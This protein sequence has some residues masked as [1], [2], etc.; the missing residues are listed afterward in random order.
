LLPGRTG[1]L[2][3]KKRLKHCLPAAAATAACIQAVVRA[4]CVPEPARQGEASTHLQVAR[5]R[6]G[7]VSESKR[8]ADFT[9]VPR[10]R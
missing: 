2:V 9:R 5:E 1:W 3:A 8:V 10:Q 7:A 4:R 6:P